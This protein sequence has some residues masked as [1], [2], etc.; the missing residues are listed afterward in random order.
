MA[1]NNKL[2]QCIGMSLSGSDTLSGCEQQ[3]NSV[4]QVYS[5]PTAMQ[6]A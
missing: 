3:A 6:K 5:A 4:H 2:T 1:A